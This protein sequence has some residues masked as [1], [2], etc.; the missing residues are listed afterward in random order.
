MKKTFL[1]FL[2]LLLTVVSYSFAGE[3]TFA[4]IRW[5]DD[6][7]AIIA[8][9][10]KV[11]GFTGISPQQKMIREPLWLC[12]PDMGILNALDIKPA[13]LNKKQKTFGTY[14]DTQVL[15][16]RELKYPIYSIDFSRSKL[17]DTLLMIKIFFNKDSNSFS[18]NWNGMT[19]LLFKKNGIPSKIIR[20][21]FQW[22][23]SDIEI[24][25]DESNGTV[26]YYHLLHLN[27]HCKIENLKHDSRLKG[28][29]ANFKQYF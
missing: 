27:E 1:I 2:L 29:N 16:T 20:D 8:K 14:I 10:N 6:N 17:T 13:A 19:D 18:K 11:Q 15:N 24:D 21:T 3:P 12:S 4:D 22:V 5:T 28:H 25:A 26:S 9:I 23:M 7:D